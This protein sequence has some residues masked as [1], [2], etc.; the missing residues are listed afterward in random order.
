MVLWA[1][2]SQER[3]LPGSPLLGGGGNPRARPSSGG[4]NASEDLGEEEADQVEAN[5]A[6]SGG[7]RD[8]SGL[9]VWAKEDILG[10]SDRG[11]QR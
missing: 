1:A 8:G 9:R 3:W 4:L 5:P 10:D 6:G 2:V 11:L 7:P